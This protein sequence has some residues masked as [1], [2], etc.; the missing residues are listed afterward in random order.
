MCVNIHINKK[1]Y[2]IVMDTSKFKP[3]ANNQSETK[4]K[5]YCQECNLCNGKLVAKLDI[6]LCS[7]CKQNEK[8]KLISGSTARST[9]F[10]RRKD[11]A[12]EKTY[13]KGCCYYKEKDVK[14]VFYRKYN[15][16]GENYQ[17][18]MRELE[19]RR[20]EK[21]E[22][23][24]KRRVE[25][26]D[27][28]DGIRDT[29][30]KKFEDNNIGAYGWLAWNNV[31]NMKK[32]EQ[33]NLDYDK[34]LADYILLKEREQEMKV[35]MIEEAPE[36]YEKYYN[37]QAIPRLRSY[38]GKVSVDYHKIIGEIKEDIKNEKI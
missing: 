11:L 19:E 27:K 23:D 16:A 3:T 14:E 26:K 4:K 22:K 12:E 30:Y 2:T 32:V 1:K 7:A 35:A 29:V 15:V 8:Y 38:I 28:L 6:V 31:Y 24:S 21:N 5:G 25:Y 9:Y 33:Y 36:L 10:L 37:Y 18:K 13:G 34:L 17:E 20:N